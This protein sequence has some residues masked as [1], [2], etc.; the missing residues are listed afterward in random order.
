MVVTIP[1]KCSPSNTI[2]RWMRLVNM[3]LANSSTGVSGYAVITPVDIRSRTRR[4]SSGSMRITSQ[5]S[6]WTSTWVW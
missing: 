3:I 2:R 5:L 1:A 6:E 4:S